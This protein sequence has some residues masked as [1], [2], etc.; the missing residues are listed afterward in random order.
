MIENPLRISVVGLGKLGYPLALCF[1]A[2]GHRVVGADLNPRTVDLITRGLSPVLESGVTALLQDA[3]DRFIATLDN[4]QAIL[5]SDVTLVIVPTP[6]QADGTFSN[7]YVL[8]ACDAIGRGLADKSAHHVV[9][10]VST[11]MPGSTGGEIRSKLERVSGKSCGADFGLA[12]VP[13]FI[14]LG[15]V[16]WDFLHPDFL[17]IGESDARS[18][19]LLEELYTGVCENTPKTARMNFINAELTKL[20]TNT[21]VSTK[22]TF[23]NLLAQICEQLPDAH[24]DVVTS[25]LGL[26]SRIGAKYLKGG[27][28]YGGPCLVRDSIAMAALAQST[29]GTGQLAEATHDANQNEVVRLADLIKAKRSPNGTVGVL[30]LSYKANTDVIDAS[31]GVL[32]CQALAA[33]G[34]PVVTYDPAAMDQAKRVLESSVRFAE[35]AKACIQQS[36]LVVITT[37]WKEFQELEPEAFGPSGS[38]VLVD[39]WRILEGSKT[40]AVTDY[41][42]LGVGPSPRS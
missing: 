7:K 29:G 42:P 4:R 30:G 36:D 9:V 12:Y 28:G 33:Q 34:V 5:D 11:V 40:K 19:D 37:P 35:S 32:L 2:K 6:S 25:A 31:P 8:D 39:C 15:S 14:A 22:I 21:F 1:A 10:L 20:A 16:V 26:D 23:A 38:R 3:E 41:V 13:S 24:V 18:G 17:L 27:M